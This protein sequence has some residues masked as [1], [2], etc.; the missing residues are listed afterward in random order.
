MLLLRAAGLYPL[1]V[2]KLLVLVTTHQYTAESV[3][4]VEVLLSLC[5]FLGIGNVDFLCARQIVSP[6]HDV[7][8]HTKILHAEKVFKSLKITVLKIS[9]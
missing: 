9:V 6:F 5:E 7:F 3:S 8:S 4:V 1:Q 2:F